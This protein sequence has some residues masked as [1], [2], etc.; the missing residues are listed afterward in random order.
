LEDKREGNLPDRVIADSIQQKVLETIERTA[1]LVSLAPAENLKWHPP[2]PGN[3]IAA[4]DL[5]HLLGHL[6]DCLAGFC[7]AFYAAFPARLSDF[8]ALRSLTVNHFCAREEA[9]IRIE[10][11][12]TCIVRAFECCSDEDLVRELPTTFVPSG[13]PLVTVLL[14]NLEHLINHKYQLFFYLK[15]LGSP[16]GTQDLYKLRGTPRLAG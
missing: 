1:H 9:T 2:S 14:G 4:I 11:Y 12:S 15:L 8:H 16:V 5:G 6:L 3:G 10:T 13:E 7:A